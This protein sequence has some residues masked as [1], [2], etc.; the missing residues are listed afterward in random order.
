MTWR[1]IVVN[2]HVWQT[3]QQENLMLEAALHCQGSIWVISTVTFLGKSNWRYRWLHDILQTQNETEI[4]FPCMLG[5]EVPMELVGSASMY[6]NSKMLQQRN[7]TCYFSCSIYRQDLESKSRR[8]HATSA[9][10]CA[11][12]Q[13]RTSK[14]KSGYVDK[15]Q[16]QKPKEF[17]I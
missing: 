6:G 16:T 17:N 8:I 1:I 4:V 10:G 2:V 3:C 12:L 11:S 15:K 14:G 5:L 13:S 9:W 7:C